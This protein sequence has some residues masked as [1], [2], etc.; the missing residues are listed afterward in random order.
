MLVAVMLW[1]PEQDYLVF[2]FFGAYVIPI[3]IVHCTVECDAQWWARIRYINAP[4][5]QLQVAYGVQFE[6]NLVSMFLGAYVIP[7]LIVLLL[8]RAVL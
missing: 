6:T 7:I 5:D 1:C 3:L 2:M 4:K 8:Q